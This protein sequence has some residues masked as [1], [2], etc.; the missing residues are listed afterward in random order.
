MQKRGTKNLTCSYAAFMNKIMKYRTRKNP[1]K[2][3]DLRTFPRIT[4]CIFG[5]CFSLSFFTIN[6]KIEFRE[7]YCTFIA[8]SKICKT[9][10]KEKYLLDCKLTL[11]KTRA[12][13]KK[14]THFT[15]KIERF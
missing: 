10:F 12:S 5:E 13:K 6:E 9:N 11:L 1:I 14:G 2:Q 8:F 3:N 15:E 4:V 7:F